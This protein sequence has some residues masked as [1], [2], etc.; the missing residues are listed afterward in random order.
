[1]KAISCYQGNGGHRNALCIGGPQDLTGQ[2]YEWF[3]NSSKVSL[4]QWPQSSSFRTPNPLFTT[5]FCLLLYLFIF[6]IFQ[7]L[8]SSKCSTNS[9]KLKGTLFFTLVA[10]SNSH[11]NFLTLR[12]RGI[13][14][15]SRFQAC[16]KATNSKLFVQC[17]Q[18]FFFFFA[19]EA[20]F[21]YPPEEKKNPLFENIDQLSPPSPAACMEWGASA[22]QP[23]SPHGWGYTTNLSIT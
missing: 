22:P 12:G 15:W 3:N 18:S 4:S 10:F 14:R 17:H 1:M 2:Q 9:L 19:L 16:N 23:P 20:N 21:S 13:T 5:H 7:C 6:T 11:Q 8:V